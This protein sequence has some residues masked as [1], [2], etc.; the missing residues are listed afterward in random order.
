[1]LIVSRKFIVGPITCTSGLGC[2]PPVLLPLA[3]V[4]AISRIAWLELTRENM[5]GVMACET[6]DITISEYMDFLPS[7]QLLVLSTWLNL[8]P[9]A[10]CFFLHGERARAVRGGV[11]ERELTGWHAG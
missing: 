8:S 6:C 3:P 4:A 10:S 11:S 2:L 5:L 1:M 7:R 9:V